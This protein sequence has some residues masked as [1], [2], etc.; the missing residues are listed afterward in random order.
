MR[1]APV[2]YRRAK[3]RTPG[4][5]RQIAAERRSARCTEC[6]RVSCICNKPELH[7]DTCMCPACG[8][9]TF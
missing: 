2:N 5:A 7:A 1:D 9:Q 4:L 3:D 6:D 8:E